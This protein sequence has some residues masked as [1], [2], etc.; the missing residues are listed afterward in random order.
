MPQAEAIR[1]GTLPLELQLCGPDEDLSPNDHYHHGFPTIDI[2]NLINAQ[3]CFIEYCHSAGM[4]EKGLLRKNQAPGNAAI[5]RYRM[6]TH[7]SLLVDT[8]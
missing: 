8:V 3:T 1:H 5:T 2:V 4:L 6:S 7:L